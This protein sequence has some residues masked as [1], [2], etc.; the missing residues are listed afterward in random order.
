MSTQIYQRDGTTKTRIDVIHNADGSVTVSGYD[1]GAAP[2]AA[3]GRDELDYELRIP[4]H[5]VPAAVTALL[6]AVL[7]PSETPM[8]T[9]RAALEAD[10]VDH[11]FQILP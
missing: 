8:T 6:R 5:A 1:W 3:F 7:A 11:K 2:E 9:L 10:Q 4:A